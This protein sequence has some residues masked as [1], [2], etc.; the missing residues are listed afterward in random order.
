MNKDDNKKTP[1]ITLC[2]VTIAVGISSGLLGMSLALFLHYIQHIAYGYSPLHIISNESFLEGVRTSSSERRV[3]VLIIC[4]LIAGIGWAAVYQLGKPL[5]S[6][7]EALKTN[8]I[9]PVISTTFHALLQIIT[10]ALGS[11]LGRE[12]A[13]R[14]V[15]AVFATLLSQKAGLS[16]TET[17]IMLA[18]GAGAGLAAVYNVPFGGAIFVLEVLLCTFSWSVVL[19]ALVTSA[20]ATVVSWWGLGSAPLYHIKDM[21]L[22][23]SLVFWAIVSGPV[24]GVAAFWFIYIATLARNHARRNWQMIFSCLLNFTLI[25]VLAIYY[26]VLLGNGKSPAQLEFDY[27]IGI[28]LSMTLLVLRCII[29]W[30]SLR[31]G[32]QGGLLTPSLANGAL[33]GAILGGLWTMFWP[34]SSFEAFALIGAAAFLGAAQKMPITAVILIFELT[35]VDLNLLPPILFALTG[36]ISMFHLCKNYYIKLNDS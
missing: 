3:I 11:P 36:S 20:I 17:K 14:E 10:I 15:S 24:F 26:P 29:V 13:P 30:S 21:E 23:Y 33:L 7:A 22:S 25:G 16:I 2:L 18:C 31:V 5:V 27:S 28:G 1:L 34:T 12:V 8:K 35:R 19:P 4:G 32:A 9:M 6:I